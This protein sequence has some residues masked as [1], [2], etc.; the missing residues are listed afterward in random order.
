M[1]DH[2]V[3]SPP[4]HPWPMSP[5]PPEPWC[6]HAPGDP[7]LSAD[8]SA[9]FIDTTPARLDA[10]RQALE[11]GARPDLWLLAHQLAGTC[12]TLGLHRMAMLFTELAAAAGR[13]PLV[14]AETLL[15]RS[16]TAFDQTKDVLLHRPW[17][18]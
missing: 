2:L 16:Q 5:F 6:P 13:G 14:D 10:A 8:L 1:D 18:A 12:A 7:A 9:L 3:E 11:D 15:A 4:V 17:D